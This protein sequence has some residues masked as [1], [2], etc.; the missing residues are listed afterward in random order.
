MFPFT[1]MNDDVERIVKDL[2][3]GL[4]EEGA[5][6]AEGGIGANTPEM[7]K[8]DEALQQEGALDEQVA[9]D[10]KPDSDQ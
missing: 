10:S 1:P 9:E 3:H 2:E 4:P 7:T 6:A 5:P 8:A